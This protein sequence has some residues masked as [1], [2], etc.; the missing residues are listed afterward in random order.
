MYQKAYVGKRGEQHS[1]VWEPVTEQEIIE[2]T[3][4]YQFNRLRDGLE[5]RVYG[6]HTKH[7][8]RKKSYDG[9]EEQ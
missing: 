9:R 8:Y 5:D 4:L 1:Y 3:S 2:A 6:N 7:Y